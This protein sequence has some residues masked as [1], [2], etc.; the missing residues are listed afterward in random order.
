MPPTPHGEPGRR[1]RLN[2]QRVLR[3]AVDLADSIGLPTLSMRRLAG[4]LGVA[5]MAL[6]KHVTDKDDLLDGM[7]DVVIDE[8]APPRTELPWRDEV[9]DRILEARRVV[10]LHPWARQAIES[11]TRRTVTVLGHLDAVTAAFLRGGLSPQL[12]HHVMHAI[13]NRVWGFSPEMFNPPADDTDRPT[14]PD[15]EAL[16]AFVTR[17]PAIAAVAGAATAGDPARLVEGCDEDFE[18]RFALDLLLDGADRLHR[19]EPWVT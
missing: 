3:G 7:V 17:F 6:Y 1:E 13:G 18:F 9:R 10:L 14:A 5:P 2:R 15:P 4:T 12:T 11:R 19:S 16:A 8:F